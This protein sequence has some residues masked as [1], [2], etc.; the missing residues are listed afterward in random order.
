MRGGSLRQSPVGHYAAYATMLHSHDTKIVGGSDTVTVGDGQ[1]HIQ[2]LNCSLRLVTAT[3]VQRQFQVPLLPPPLRTLPESCHGLFRNQAQCCN[4]QH[5]PT[6]MHLAC[7]SPSP[8]SCYSAAGACLILRNNSDTITDLLSTIDCSCLHTA[9]LSRFLHPAAGT[10]LSAM[11]K[12]PDTS[13]TILAQLKALSLVAQS[14]VVL[15]DVR[16]RGP[17]GK[18]SRGE[19]E[20]NEAGN[21]AAQPPEPE[22]RL[23]DNIPRPLTVMAASISEILSLR[24]RVGVE[25]VG[26][27]GA[28]GRDSCA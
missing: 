17:G 8:S 7:S 20:D 5:G 12:Q 23:A 24:V 16:G 18:A 14:N 28:S 9:L 2:T 4:N 21:V 11:K 27:I 25:C 22:L 1:Q 10:V 3:A 26:G 15:E 13:A 6:L 19:E